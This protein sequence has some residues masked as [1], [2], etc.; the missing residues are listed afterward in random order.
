[1]A[2]ASIVT[3]Q[4]LLFLTCN[5]KCIERDDDQTADVDVLWAVQ[6][7]IAGGELVDSLSKSL[8]QRR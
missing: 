6:L 8:R 3:L 1:M 5:R 7:D 4:V 2:S